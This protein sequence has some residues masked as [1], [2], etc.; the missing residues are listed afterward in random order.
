MTAM[1]TLLVS[2]G[3]VFAK[4]VSFIPTIAGLYESEPVL[5]LT[6]AFVV[7]GF[8]VGIFGRLLSRG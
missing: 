3:E 5:T 2:I 6:V 4:V 7:A 1:Q 8:A